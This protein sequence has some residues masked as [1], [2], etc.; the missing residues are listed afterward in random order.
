MKAL[1]FAAFPS[2]LL[3]TTLLRLSLNVAS[4]RVVLMEGHTGPGRRGQGDRGLR[5]LPGRRQLRR[6]RDGL[7]H[8][9]GD[10]L[11]GD[12]QGRRAASP[13]W[14]RASRWTRCPASRWP[15]MPTSTPASIGRGRGTPAPRRSGAGSRLLRLHGRRQQVRARRRGRRPADPGDQHRRRADRRHGPARAGLSRFGRSRT[16]TL[17]AIGDGLV[18]QIPALVISTAAGVIVS[19]VATDEDVGRPAHR[20]AVR[21]P[22]GAVPDGRRRSA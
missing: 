17:L 5:P 4:T 11:H 15:S 14:A 16:Y 13:R 22:A 1:D 2:V 10:Q 6:R 8:P 20:P 3:F 7:H 18:A 12:H 21:E 9:G 19:R